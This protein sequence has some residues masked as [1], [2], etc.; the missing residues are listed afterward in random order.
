MNSEDES[1]DPWPGCV[2][3]RT[4]CHGYYHRTRKYT[5]LTAFATFFKQDIDAQVTL[6]DVDTIVLKYAEEKS[7]IGEY[8]CTISYDEG[9][10]A[11]FGLER[12]TV[13]K[14]YQIERLATPHLVVIPESDDSDDEWQEVCMKY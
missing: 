12:Q 13:L 8:T 9:L 6:H 5:M 4:G 7:L 11:L 10:W 14:Y 2:M 1:Y 3:D